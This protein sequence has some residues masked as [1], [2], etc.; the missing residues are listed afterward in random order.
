MVI[1]FI[2]YILS[3]IFIFFSQS[4]KKKSAM[5]KYMLALCAIVVL[6][7]LSGLSSYTVGTDK[8]GYVNPIFFSAQQF[9]SLTAL[10]GLFPNIE[11]G[12]LLFNIIISRVI[13]NIQFYYF[14]STFI[15]CFLF[16][17]S[18][19]FFEDQINIVLAWF[20]YLAVFFAVTFCLF[21]QGL[22]VSFVTFA[23]CI[24]IKYGKN[25]ILYSILM[26]FLGISFHFSAVFGFFLLALIIFIRKFGSHGDKRIIIIGSILIIC[27][28]ASY[29]L[30]MLI[31]LG[32]LSNKYKDYANG[33]L[34]TDS[35]SIGFSIFF[36]FFSIFIWKN[37]K[38]NE[39]FNISFI[40]AIVNVG[41]SNL[42][43][44]SSVLGRL[45]LYLKIFL[46]IYYCLLVKNQYFFNIK[47]DILKACF[48]ILLISYLMF[49]NN[50]YIFGIKNQEGLGTFGLY[51][52]EFYFK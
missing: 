46:I 25:K 38:D 15:I 6:S 10:K 44:I 28:N 32:V 49:S 39:L 36:I 2:A 19:T 43:S 22:A 45:S 41:I 17:I 51:P 35:T 50:G 52:Y 11:S 34:G 48:L 14:I 37:I 9:N 20:V 1:Y 26:I 31:R 12:Y 29:I 42:E 7:G 47:R 33:F 30:P 4:I 24:Y 23:L 21:R 40:L 3:I 18:L 8:L 27:L 16:Y 13:G 5:L